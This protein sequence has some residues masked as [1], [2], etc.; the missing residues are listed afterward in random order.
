QTLAGGG[1]TV[2]VISAMKMEE[3]FDFISTGGGAMLQFLATE[4]LPGIEALK[5]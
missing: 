4:T 5:A 3:K 2:A 1:D